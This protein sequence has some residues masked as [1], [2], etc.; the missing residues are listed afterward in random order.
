LLKLR[1]RGRLPRLALL[2]VA[3]L[4]AMAGIAFATTAVTNAFTDSQ[5]VYHGCVGNGSGNLRV[6]TPGEGCRPSETAIDW[7]RVGPQGVQGPTGAT[8]S[9]GPKG[10]PGTQGP[11]GPSFI[12]SACTYD[13]GTPG[14]VQMSNP[15]TNGIVTLRCAATSTG[16]GGGNLCP[17]PLPT[18][19]NATTM[20]DGSTG[21]VSISCNIGWA[22]VNGQIQDGCETQGHAPEVCNG[23]DDDHDGVVDDHLVDVPLLPHATALCAPARGGYVIQ[24]CDPGWQDADG[25][26]ADGCEKQ[27]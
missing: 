17:S 24:S 27:L 3:G 16:G 20:C 26:V 4:A 21:T 14:T 1:A 8:G 15:G 6:V 13:D 12:G 2:T 19:P 11:T 5:G 22:D 23:L 7:N 10:D 25:V 9:Q 18:Y